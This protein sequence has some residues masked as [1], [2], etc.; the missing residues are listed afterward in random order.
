MFEPTRREGVLQLAGERRWLS[1]GYGGGFERA[2]AAYNI[3]V[4]EGWAREDIEQYS[5]ERREAA[6]FERAGPTLLTGVEMRHAR[7][8]RLGPVVAYATV[9]LSNPATLPVEPE[10]THEGT[11]DSDESATVGTINIIVGTSHSLTEGAQTNLVSVVAEAKT[12][13]LLEVAGVTGTTT[14]AIVVGSA[15]EG[16]KTEFTGSATAVGAAARACVRE[17]VVAAFDARYA[18]SEPPTTVDRAEYGVVTD[19]RATVFN[20]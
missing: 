1:T 11:N 12:A 17:A 6:G 3:T 8:A 7:G 16:S 20:P 2:P 14:D 4:P 13:T 18:D 19:Q 9:G 10:D 5:R 15:T